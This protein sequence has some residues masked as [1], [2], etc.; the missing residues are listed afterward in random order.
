MVYPNRVVLNINQKYVMPIPYTQQGDTARV[1]TFNI[2]D[3]GVPFSL[4]GK[5]VR[6]RIAKP[7]KTKCYNDLTIT[8]A[9]NGECT[10]KLTNQILAVAGNVNC[11]LEIKEGEELLSTIIFSID[12]EPSID[13][14]GA[15]ESTNEFTALL[16]GIIKLDEWD[17]YFKETSGKIEEKYTERLSGLATSLE[18]KV[19]KEQGKG[20]S[21]NDYTTDEKN[22]L[23]GIEARAN[24]YTHP[25]THL[26]TIITED[27]THRFT[28]DAEKTTWNNTFR[29]DSTKCDIL[30][31]KEGKRIAF[32]HGYI[33]T[34]G[35]EYWFTVTF[36]KAF[37]DE[38][39][40]VV[41]SPFYKSAFGSVSVSN[42]TPSSVK[43][44]AQSGVL[45]VYWLAIGELAN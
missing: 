33:K 31:T 7:D 43:V 21:T 4:Q 32:Q 8:N 42:L 20:L 44:C 35:N 14:S 3:N 2:L 38:Y 9:T 30:T 45:Y 6:A 27:S 34:D 1:L 36:P 16:N 22:K 28:T 12:V 40:D 17:K 13:I 23:S 29:R 26:A 37:K 41:V 24:A 18:E 25:P 15:V 10:L 19:N 5:T 11:Q 39:Y